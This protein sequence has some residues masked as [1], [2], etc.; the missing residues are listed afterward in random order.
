M[1]IKHCPKCNNDKS[2]DNFYKAKE[3]KDGL[4]AICKPCCSKTYNESYHRNKDGWVK[5]NK[6]QIRT[7]NI[8]KRFNITRNEYDEIISNPCMICGGK[9]DIVL[10]HSHETGLIRGPLCRN[11][12]TGLGL[13]TDNE[14]KLNNAIQYLRKFNGPITENPQ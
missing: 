1:F 8:K 13:F 3:R 4:R 9:E 5:R 12:N 11:C 14:G 2:I 6:Y 10:D 7:A